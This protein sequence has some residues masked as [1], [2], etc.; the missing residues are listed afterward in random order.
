MKLTVDQIVEATKGEIVHRHQNS[1]DFFGI[2]S[3]K[4]P[5]QGLFFAMRGENTDGHLFLEN[6]F[7][8]GAGGAIIER[9]P[10]FVS[11]GK[12]IIKVT[13]SMRAIQDLAAY[14]RLRSVS[15]YIGIT[16]SSGKTSTKEFTAHLLSQKYSVYKS[17]G[18]LNSLTGIPLS[19]LSMEQKECSVFEVAMNHPGEIARLSEVL[20]PDI[21]VV[22]NVNPV[23][24]QQFASIEAIADEKSSLVQGMAEDALLVYNIDDPLLHERLQH[25]GVKYTYGLSR[26]ASLR[27]TDI[28]MRGVKGSHAVLRFDGSQISIETSLSGMGN[29]YNIAAASAVALHMQLSPEEIAA[30]IPELKPYSQRGLLIEGYGF[31]IYD[32]TYNSNPRALEMVLHMGGQSAGYKRK[33][34][35]LGDMLELGPQ[36]Q[37][38]H[39]AAGIH[40]AANRFAVLVA[41]GA[42]SKFTAEAVMDR[43]VEVYTFNTAD[44]AAESLENIVREGDLVVVKG[45]RGMKMERVVQR[46][47]GSEKWKVEGG[48][49]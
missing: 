11:S 43:G 19:I 10:G 38:F 16:G 45:S 1:F 32:D 27:I 22:L 36:E 33:I 41:V 37:Q 8:N 23:H 9:I 49:K 12:T 15:K 4:I 25:R 3:R 34:A 47:T 13:D 14:V 17:E 2:D 7:A 29:L 40:V 42:L 21:G 18:N 30:S 6:A 39:T 24:A 46:L 35:V 20:K 31:H 44:E 5:K 26:E 48:K 28:R